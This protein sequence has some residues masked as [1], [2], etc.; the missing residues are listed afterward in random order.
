LLCRAVDTVEDDRR[1]ARP[2]R[3]ALFAAFDRSLVSAA[4]GRP[5]VPC[6]FE[7]LAQEI[8]LGDDDANREL[9]VAS[10]ALFRAFA[11]LPAAQRRVIV[12]R[13][14]E[15][16]SGMF[17]YCERV[18]VDGGLR[19]RDVDDLERYCYHVAGTVGEFLTDLFLLEC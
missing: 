19:L 17:A 12:P 3:V 2:A 16:S 15:M 14:I 6:P 9:C 1:L 18:E 4:S 10:S 7:T 13:V 8:G 11:S 5:P